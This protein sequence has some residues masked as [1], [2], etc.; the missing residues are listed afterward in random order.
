MLR[1]P[2]KFIIVHFCIFRYN[3]MSEAINIVTKLISR[4]EE[5]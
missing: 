3:D 5:I 2:N 1:M 4:Q